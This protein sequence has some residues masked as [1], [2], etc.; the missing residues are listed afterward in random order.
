VPGGGGELAG[1]GDGGLVAATAQGDGETPLLQGVDG[2]E[3]THAGLHE[4]RAH[5]AAAVGAQGGGAF[6][7]SALD[8]AGIKPEVGDEFLHSLL[9]CDSSGHTNS[10]PRRPSYP[11]RN[12]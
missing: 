5:L 6:G 12:A 7:L 3:Q 8:D 11:N 1:D 9:R 4:E 2:G 10:H